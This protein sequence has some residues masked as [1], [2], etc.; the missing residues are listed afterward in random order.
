MYEKIDKV[1]IELT[2]K[3]NS[4]CPQCQRTDAQNGCKPYSWI[5]NIEWSFEDFKKAFPD[6]KSSGINM[7]YLCGS[8]GDPLMCNDLYEIVKDIME[9]SNSQVFISTN[10]SVRNEDWWFIFSQW[11]N[12]VQINFAIDGLEDTNHLYRV[13][14]NFKKIMLNAQA[15]IDGKGH[16]NWTFIVFKHNQHQVEEAKRLSIEMGFKSFEIIKFIDSFTS[17]EN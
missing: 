12:R 2:D 7:F 5:Q 8:F 1:N 11:G 4:R 17:N 9:N 16:A 13:G 6:P 14:T 3:C 10:A 15:F